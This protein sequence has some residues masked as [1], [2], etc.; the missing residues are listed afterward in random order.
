MKKVGIIAVVALF[1]ILLLT[2]FTVNED[3]YACVKRFGKII[4][5]RDQPGIAFKIPFMDQIITL[6]NTK[7]IYDLTASDVLTADKKAMVIDNYVLWKIT[8]PIQFVKSVTYIA[9]AEKRIDAAVYNVVK[10]TMGTLQQNE[11]INEK[12]S[13]RG[14][15]NQTVTDAVSKQLQNYGISVL[16][17]QIKRLDLPAAN[18]NAV[19]SRMVSEREKIAAQFKAEGE[20]DASKIKNEVSKEVSILLS[21]ARAKEQELIGEGEASYMKIVADAYSGDKL[22]FYEYIRTLE[23]MKKSL[24]GNK[25]LILPIDSPITKYL[26]GKPAGN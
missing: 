2:S 26:T 12:Q 21:Q 18:E 7:I 15:F 3:E 5:V 8:D 1:I 24:K 17:V 13:G 6:P 25:T 11:I 19:F 14:K 4:E 9:E 16:D 23:A 10:N 22:E 20:F